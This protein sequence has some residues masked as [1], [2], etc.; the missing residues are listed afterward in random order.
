MGLTFF[1]D[2]YALYELIEG[3][4]NYEPYKKDMS[5]ITTKLNLMELHYGM[6]RVYGKEKANE[7]FNLFLEFCIPFDDETIKQANEFRLLNKKRKLSYIDCIGYILAKKFNAKFL[8]GDIQ[9]QDLENVEFVKSQ[10]S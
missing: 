10:S 5:M 8:T 1:F 2:T 4:Q 7:V 6:L 9:F 3:N